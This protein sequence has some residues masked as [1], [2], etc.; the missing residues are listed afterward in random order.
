MELPL[1]EQM[2]VAKRQTQVQANLHF[3]APLPLYETEKPYLIPSPPKGVQG[4]KQTNIH[5]EIHKIEFNDVR[6]L[7]KNRYTLDEHGFEYRSRNRLDMDDAA[8]NHHER[9]KGGEDS[10]RQ[11]LEDALG[12]RSVIIFDIVVGSFQ[13]VR[14]RSYSY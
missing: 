8:S 5:K 11:W 6:A 1:P 7:G 2:L 4:L 13:K 12:A 14:L 10:I 9:L 3:I